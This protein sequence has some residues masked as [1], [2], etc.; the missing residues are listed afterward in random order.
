MNRLRKIKDLWLIVPVYPIT[1]TFEMVHSCKNKPGLRRG[2]PNVFLQIL[3]FPH[4]LEPLYA[5][6]KF[7]GSA[8]NCADTT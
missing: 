4:S 1:R 2:I 7:Y 8:V 5:E 6:L 3:R